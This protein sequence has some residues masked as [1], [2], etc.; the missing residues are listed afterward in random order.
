MVTVNGRPCSKLSTSS[1]QNFQSTITS[2]VKTPLSRVILGCPLLSGRS[3]LPI[4]S[5]FSGFRVWLKSSS[6]T[7]GTR[8]LKFQLAGLLTVI[9]FIGQTGVSV[10]IASFFALLSIN[11]NGFVFS[12]TVKQA[13][14]RFSNINFR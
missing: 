1:L 10:W 2:A 5:T 12:S 7:A 13:V 3:K 6:C 4:R 8:K 11:L 9:F 14:F